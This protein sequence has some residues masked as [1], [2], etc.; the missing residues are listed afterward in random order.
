M[1]KGIGRYLKDVAH[2][3]KHSSDFRRTEYYMRKLKKKGLEKREIHCDGYV[4]VFY[5]EGK[6]ETVEVTHKGEA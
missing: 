1:F 3:A 2:D 4:M 6:Y 5:P